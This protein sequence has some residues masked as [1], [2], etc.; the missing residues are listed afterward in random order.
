MHHHRTCPVVT[1]SLKD[2]TSISSQLFCINQLAAEGMVD[3]TVRVTVLWW[4]EVFHPPLRMYSVCLLA[5]VKQITSTVWHVEFKCSADVTPCGLY[6]TVGC[7]E[8][9]VKS[10]LLHQEQRQLGFMVDAIDSIRDKFSQWKKSKNSE[11]NVVCSP[12]CT[13]W[14]IL[15]YK[16]STALFQVYMGL[17]VSDWK[18]DSFNVI[19]MTSWIALLKYACSLSLWV[20]GQKM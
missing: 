19:Y 2:T 1:E 6:R 14:S 12:V 9:V 10:L 5:P 8:M 11:R 18:I 15:L 7:R 16:L 17:R 4:C 13:Y 20:V 3:Q